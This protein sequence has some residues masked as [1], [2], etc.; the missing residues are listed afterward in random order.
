MKAPMGVFGLAMGMAA[1]PSN[2]RLI[3]QNRAIEALTMLRSAAEV[4]LVLVGISQAAL[5]VSSS[6]MAAL[7]WG[8]DHLSFGGAEGIGLYC[9]A[10]CLGLWGWS[11]QGLVA[12]GFYARG[13][14]WAPTLIG[15]VIAGL[16][17]PLYTWVGTKGGPQ[18]GEYLAPLPFSLLRRAAELPGIGLTLVSSAAISLYVFT[19]WIAL[20]LSFGQRHVSTIMGLLKTLLKIELAA[21]LAVELCER[22]LPSVTPDHSLELITHLIFRVSLSTIIFLG[23]ALCLRVR[24]LAVLRE[25]VA[26]RIMRK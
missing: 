4:L 5:M 18:I 15:S 11:M 6:Q 20:S 8:S 3:A 21:L 7:I 10:L 24:A 1:F 26:L 25:R 2:S 17:Y 22:L 23:I 14:T 12:R 13:Q 19:L 16:M 9:A